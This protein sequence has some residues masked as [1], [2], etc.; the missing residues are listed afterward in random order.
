MSTTHV[1]SN[2]LTM[3]WV[4][5]PLYVFRRPGKHIF[6]NDSYWLIFSRKKQK[7]LHIRYFH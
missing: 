6:N 1:Y 3:F 5:H 4:I 7:L 2:I